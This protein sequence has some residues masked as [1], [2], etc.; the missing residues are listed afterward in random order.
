MFKNGGL[1]AQKWGCCVQEIR[2]Q[3]NNHP[4][5]AKVSEKLLIFVKSY[6]NRPKS[7]IITLLIYF[8]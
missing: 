8:I 5:F 7:I 2:G 3:K 6:L 1:S 4:K